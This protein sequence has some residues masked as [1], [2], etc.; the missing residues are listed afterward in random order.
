MKADAVV[1]EIREQGY[2]V[3]RN[4]IPDVELSAIGQELRAAQERRDTESRAELE[5]IR[6]RGHRVGAAGVG[7]LKQAINETQCFAPYVA[8][9][10]L[11]GIVEAFFGDFVRISC[12]DCVVTH[13][14]S[15]RGPWHADWPYNS[16]NTTHVKAPYPDAVMHLSTIWM[17]TDFTADNGAT[18]LL[19]KSH[20]RD[21][22]PVDGGM[23]GVNADGDLDGQQRA[24]GSAG[25][26]LVYDSRLW[27]AVAANRSDD[28]RI[29]LVIRYAPW[30]LNLTPT[31]RGTPDNERMVQEIGGK[32]YDA[33]PLKRD[34]FDRLPANVK[35]LY[36]HWVI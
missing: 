11:V 22:N 26:V 15:E 31:M 24:I 36:R 8:D 6:S 32:S 17:I 18:T 5:Q 27:H 3:V 19:P 13:S 10:R 14:G 28:V 12:T 7:V 34:V 33:I 4:V 23:Q 25:S 29:A 30:W 21:S 16:T 35:P 2:S 1:S 20:L 9:P